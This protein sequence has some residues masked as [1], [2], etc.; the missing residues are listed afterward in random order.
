M[1]NV[2]DP[3]TIDEQKWSNTLKLR[4]EEFRVIEEYSEDDFTVQNVISLINSAI[5]E[6]EIEMKETVRD[7][8]CTKC[9]R[10][11]PDN[12]PERGI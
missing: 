5:E 2:S 8:A 12:P 6:T 9:E 7:W 10:I 4:V 3:A 11:D 1:I